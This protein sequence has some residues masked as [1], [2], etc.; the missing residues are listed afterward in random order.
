MTRFYSP[1]TIHIQ[2]TVAKKAFSKSSSIL[3]TVLFCF[4]YGRQQW[5][6]MSGWQMAILFSQLDFYSVFSFL[7]QA[8]C[9]LPKRN[10]KWGCSPSND[11]VPDA[12][13]SK[14][15]H[16]QHQNRL[17]FSSRWGGD[18]RSM[19]GTNMQTRIYMS[20]C[21]SVCDL[22]KNKKTVIALVIYV[23][24]ESRRSLRKAWVNRTLIFL[25]PLLSRGWCLWIS[26]W[27]CISQIMRCA[28]EWLS[29][30]SPE[31]GHWPCTAGEHL[32][33]GQIKSL[34]FSSLTAI[35]FE[36]EASSASYYL[37]KNP[38]LREI[39]YAFNMH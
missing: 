9:F 2:W 14:H 25:A 39:Q 29:F 8:I 3:A 12:S 17:A 38:Q 15:H 23:K 28:S 13:N 26:F 11:F 22:N 34:H 5:H 18:Y 19:P 35:Y 6:E 37:C 10:L 1:L 16:H 36:E 27:I 31:K 32:T 21:V 33:R 30:I 4:M 7:C 24:V 20:V